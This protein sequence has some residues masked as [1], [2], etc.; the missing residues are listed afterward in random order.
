MDHFAW[1][2]NSISLAELRGPIPY[3]NVTGAG[4]ADDIDVNGRCV[5]IYRGTLLEPE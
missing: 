4:D 1:P 2:V 3:P 5:F